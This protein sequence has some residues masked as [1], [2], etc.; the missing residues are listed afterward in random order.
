MR[1]ANKQPYSSYFVLWILLVMLG[2]FVFASYISVVPLISILVSVNVA[3][4][5]LYGWDKFQSTKNGARVPEKILWLTV[6]LGGTA[7]ALIGMYTFKHKTRKSSF[8]VVVALI[9]LVQI[10]LLVLVWE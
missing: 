1:F 6:L 9:M 5:A 3:T 4:F 2:M 8:Q 7:G 10:G